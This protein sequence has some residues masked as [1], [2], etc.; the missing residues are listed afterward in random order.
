MKIVNLTQIDVTILDDNGKEVA[1]YPHA[2]LWDG[3]AQSDDTLRKVGEVDGVPLYR[4]NSCNVKNLPPYQEDICYIVHRF[5][6]EKAAQAG[7]RTADLLAP[8]N[9]VMSKPDKPIGKRGHVVGYKSFMFYA[10]ADR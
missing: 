6:A 4:P 1:F 9:P 2:E 7:R 3:V 5:V 10:P 8:S